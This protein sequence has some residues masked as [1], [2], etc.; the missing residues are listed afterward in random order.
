MI[1]F[2]VSWQLQIICTHRSKH[3]C[4]PT[5]NRQLLEN[6]ERKSTQLPGISRCFLSVL[7]LST[8]RC[9]LHQPH[10]WSHWNPATNQLGDL[11]ILGPK[12][13]I[14]VPI[15]LYHVPLKSKLGASK[16]TR[17]FKQDYLTAKKQL[18]LLQKTKERNG[19]L[20]TTNK[21]IAWT[22][23]KTFNCTQVWEYFMKKAS[24][25]TSSEAG[26]TQLFWS[27]ESR[28]WVWVHVHF[29][30]NLKLFTKRMKKPSSAWTGTHRLH[31]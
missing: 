4:L 7:H 28:V 6:F 9:C 5:S 20:A 23:E 22:E 17:S 29:S 8:L 31:Q 18:W 10:H 24:G 14:G 12:L 13:P 21:R 26:V 2:L 3:T 25:N 15:R 1:D 19:F 27:P 11:G 30:F 16:G